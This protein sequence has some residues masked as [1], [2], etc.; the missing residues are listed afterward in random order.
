MYIYLFYF[1]DKY[2]WIDFFSVNKISVCQSVYVA[3]QI[4]VIF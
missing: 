4:D 2:V 1:Y 3:K